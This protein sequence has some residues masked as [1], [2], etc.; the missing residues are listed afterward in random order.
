MKKISRILSWIIFI[1]F[2][3]LIVAGEH[4]RQ[5]LQVPSP[6]QNSTPAASPAPAA[7]TAGPITTLREMTDAERWKRALNPDY[8]AKFNCS[9]SRSKTEPETLFWQ[10]AEEKTGTGAPARC[11]EE[12]PVILTLWSNK[13]TVAYRAEQTLTL[14]THE[15]ASGLDAALIGIRPGAARTI[16]LGPD[17]QTHHPSATLPK[18][19]AAALGK[20]HIAVFTVERR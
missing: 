10:V 11:A 5:P 13:G 15:I 20:G 2:L 19:V 17:A 9:I 6:T 12:I 4:K 14:G 3:Y 1:L 7:S 18:P 16:V 8:A